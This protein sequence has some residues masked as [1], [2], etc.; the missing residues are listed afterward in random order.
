[1]REVEFLVKK[2]HIH[3]LTGTAVLLG[4]KQLGTNMSARPASLW[5]KLAGAERKKK[6]IGSLSLSYILQVSLYLR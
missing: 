5:Y 4:V 6:S 2:P 1:M 3:L